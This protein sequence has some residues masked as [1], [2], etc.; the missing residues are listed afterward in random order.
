MIQSV[1]I[2]RGFAAFYVMLYHYR[3]YLLLDHSSG[4]LRD[5]FSYGYSGVV[6]FFLISG[7]IVVVVTHDP[8]RSDPLT[9]LIRRGFRIAPLAMITTVLFF[10]VTTLLDHNSN[11]LGDLGL[12][13]SLLFMP[14][15]NA[16][17]PFYGYRILPVQWTLTY[18][19]IFYL[20]FSM[21]L[22]LSHRY[23]VLVAMISLI[24]M[25]SVAQ[26]L[27]GNL[28]LDAYAA[29]LVNSNRWYA[30]LLSLL[31]N[32]LFLL[33]L[34]GMGMAVIYTIVSPDQRPK[35]ALVFIIM[36]ACSVAYVLLF[37]RSIGVLGAIM[38]SIEIC[39]ILFFGEGMFCLGTSS[40]ASLG[41]WLGDISYSIYLIHPIVGYLYIKT[42]SSLVPVNTPGEAIVMMQVLLTLAIAHCTYRFIEQP[43]ILWGRRWARHV[44]IKPA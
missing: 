34:I 1:H 37:V 24:M 15:E 40:M 43:F 36:L 29:P 8:S 16:N 5:I 9:F 19:V 44:A 10:M 14:M 33:F 38:F 28:T 2:L 23:R 35:Y 39:G 26:C 6:L 30:G 27:F 18:E 42:L 17:P 22:W 21:S 13:Q 12:W 25:V 7:F 3:D 41:Y 4:I 11:V 31:A 20:I 32:P